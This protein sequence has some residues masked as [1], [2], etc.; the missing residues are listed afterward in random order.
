MRLSELFRAGANGEPPV[1]ALQALQVYNVGRMVNGQP[2]YVLRNFYPSL[3]AFGAIECNFPGDDVSKGPK[4][5]SVSE[6]ED[7]LAERGVAN[8]VPEA[9]RGVYCFDPAVP[10]PNL[11]AIAYPGQWTYERCKQWLE[12]RPVLTNTYGVRFV[13]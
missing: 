10:I 13:L 6:L 7:L 5:C 9:S 4:H 2:E 1:Y 8:G 3:L 12:R 11:P